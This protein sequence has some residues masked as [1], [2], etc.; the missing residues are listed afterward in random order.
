MT[1][2]DKMAA[3]EAAPSFGEALAEVEAILARLEQDEIDVD[4]LSGEV[5]RAVVLVDLCREKLR[6]TELEVQ[7][8]TARLR[9][10]R[11]AA[12]EGPPA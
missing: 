10:D 11:P 1:T 3:E 4:E 8:F 2:K 6:R 9:E 5:K 12:G 7:D